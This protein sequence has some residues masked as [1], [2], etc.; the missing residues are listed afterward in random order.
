MEPVSQDSRCPT[1]VL[2]ATSGNAVINVLLEYGGKQER[3]TLDTEIAIARQRSQTFRAYSILLNAL[4]P[5]PQSEFASKEI[6]PS[7]YQATFVVQPLISLA[8]PTSQAISVTTPQLGCADLTRRDA[9]EILGEATRETSATMNLF[10]PQENAI[11]V[12]GLCGY[13]SIAFIPNKSLPKNL[14]NVFPTT[15]PSDHAVAAGKLTD[16]KRQEQ[17]LSVASAI[18]AA[19]PNAAN[20]SAASPLYFK[21]LTI[22]ASGAWSQNLLNDFPDAARGASNVRVER[23]DGLGEKAVWVWREFSGGRYAALIAQKGENLFIVNAL[24]GEQRA[25]AGLLAAMINALKRML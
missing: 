15:L 13:G 16:S 19:N 2:C 17:L 14:P 4:T 9:E 21:L 18:Y 23:V 3:Y 7:D 1:R 6:A 8:T 20:L 12:R 5:Y 24:V 25:E 22:Y 11:T 10:Q